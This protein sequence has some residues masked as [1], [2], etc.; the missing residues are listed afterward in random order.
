MEKKKGLKRVLDW[1]NE[2]GRFNP[3]DIKT[4]AEKGLDIRFFK[5][6][7]KE[8]NVLPI[9]GVKLLLKIEKGYFYTAVLLDSEDK[10]LGLSAE[11][12][13]EKNPRDI[14]SEI[15]GLDEK[16]RGIDILL[17]GQADHLRSIEACAKKL[18]KEL[19]LL[20]VQFG[21]SEEGAFSYLQGFCP[22]KFISRVTAV[23]KEEGA[24]YL[25]EDPG[26]EDNVPTLITNPPW[27]R[28]VNPVFQFMKTVPGYREFDISP[29]F[30]IFFS[31]FFAMLIGDAGYGI[32]FLS[33]AFFIRKKFKK[34]PGEPFF[35]MYLLS[36]CT[37]VWGAITGTWF[38]VEKIAQLPFF[39]NMIIPQ[40]NS[41]SQQSQDIIIFTC[42]VIG[43]VHLTLARGLRAARVINSLV[44][45]AEIGWICIL[46]GM[47]F[48]AGKF[49]L[50]RH[51]P[52]AAGILLVVGIL[53]VLFFSNIRKG[54]LKGA[55]T[56]VTDLPLSVIGSFSD[57][58]SYLRLF[59]VGYASV[60]VAQSFNNMAVGSGINSIWGGLMA[61]V[62]LFFGHALNIILCFMA[63]IVHGIRLNMLEFSGQLGMQWSGKEYKPFRM[64]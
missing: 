56:T 35:L 1:Y 8:F 46:W 28:I 39:H 36:G 32:L 3:G 44:S 9:K 29:Y 30:L 18:E 45:L 58:V 38:G 41:F 25:I 52:P 6:R 54:L 5:L 4:L 15:D 63:V 64:E 50:G 49:V 22:V 16:I 53:L 27:I 17:R 59:A 24:G 51:F 57:I 43:A 11:D 34:L 47:F 20:E 37:I 61:A 2:W 23:T 62:V 7:K 31:I 48:A 13:P 42:F 40:I 21:M 14:L 60:V 12:I 10:V 33:A 55:L 19:E 26:E